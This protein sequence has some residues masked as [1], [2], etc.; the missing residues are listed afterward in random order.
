MNNQFFANFFRK[1][2]NLGGRWWH[3]LFLVIFFVLFAWALYMMSSDLFADNHPYVPQWKV[4]DSVDERLTPEVKQIRDLKK[5]GEQVEEKERSYALNSGDGSLYDD[6]YCSNDL[7]NKISEIQSKSGIA[8]LYLNRKNVSMDMFVNY[9]RD[10]DIKCLI[11]DAYTNADNTKLRFLEPLAP[12][13]IYGRD[14]VFYEKSNFL[15]VFYVSKMLLLV[16]A[17]FVGIAIAYYKIF[18]YVIFGKRKENI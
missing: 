1:D 3:R 12:N 14:L 5:F 18:L 13:S 17:I 15:T 10:N 4:V 11:P 7:E 9:V 8:N 2:L 16:I 6:F